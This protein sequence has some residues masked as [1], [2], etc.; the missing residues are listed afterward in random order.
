VDHQVSGYY[1]LPGAG[2][3]LLRAFWLRHVPV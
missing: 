3:L 1:G 2:S